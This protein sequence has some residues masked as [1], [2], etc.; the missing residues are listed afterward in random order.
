M[1]SRWFFPETDILSFELFDTL[2]YSVGES[3]SPSLNAYLILFN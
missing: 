3:L 2:R 1:Q